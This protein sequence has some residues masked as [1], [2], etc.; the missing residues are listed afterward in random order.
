MGRPWFDADTGDLVI[1]R[2]VMDTPSYQRVMADEQVTDDELSAQARRVSDQLSTVEKL[3][4]PEAR[5][6]LTDA[7]TELAVLNALYQ[8]RIAQDA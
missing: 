7:M 2:Y 8:K 4:P 3:L 5:D 6:A 1:D